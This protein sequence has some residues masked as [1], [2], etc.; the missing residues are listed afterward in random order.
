MRGI[1]VQIAKYVRLYA[2]EN[3]ESH[4]EDVE[5]ELQPVDFAPPAAPLNIAPVSPAEQCLWVGGPV[6]WQGDIP[7]PAP[8]RQ[9]FCTMAGVYEITASDGTSRNFPIGAVLLLEDTHGKGHSTR[10]TSDVD[11]LVFAVTLAD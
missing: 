2:D 6:G 1:A 11:A 3:G 10:I 7:H 9:I 5:T 8:N 4:F